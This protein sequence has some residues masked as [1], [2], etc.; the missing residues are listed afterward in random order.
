MGQNRDCALRGGKGFEAVDDPGYAHSGDNHARRERDLSPRIGPQ[1][2][3]MMGS[4]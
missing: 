2:S 1:L 4:S 3:V